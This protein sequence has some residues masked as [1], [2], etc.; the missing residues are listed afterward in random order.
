MSRRGGHS[1]QSVSMPQVLSLFR[2]GKWV[3]QRE[4]PESGPTTILEGRIT[5]KAVHLGTGDYGRKWGDDCEPTTESVYAKKATQE[6]AEPS[7]G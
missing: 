5:N 6:E 3:R 1:F 7:V 4:A 2:K